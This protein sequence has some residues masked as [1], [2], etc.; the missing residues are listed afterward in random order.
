M[1]SKREMPAKKSRKTIDS[2]CKIQVIQKYEGGKKVNTIA[3]DLKLS[4]SMVST[5]L[6]DK[7]RI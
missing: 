6:K 2:E 3:R 4:Y 1:S 5:I 7:E